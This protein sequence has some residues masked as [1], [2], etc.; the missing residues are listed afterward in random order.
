[1]ALSELLAQLQQKP[2]L[3]EYGAFNRPYVI[4]DVDEYRAVI[5]ALSAKRSARKA[6][7]PHQTA[8][9]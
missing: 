4:L 1:M 5:A 7:V 8:R 2:I 9:A 3:G 6:E